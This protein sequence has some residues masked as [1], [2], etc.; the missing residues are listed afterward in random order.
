[1]FRI[2]VEA[3]EVKVLATVKGRV[4]GDPWSGH[5]WQYGGDVCW[6]SGV[7]QLL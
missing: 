4:A 1:M 6:R 3:S 7:D 2:Q 5:V